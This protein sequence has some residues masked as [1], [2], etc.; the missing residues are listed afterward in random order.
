MPACFNSQPLPPLLVSLPAHPSPLSV[1]LVLLLPHLPSPVTLS[2]SRLSL[3]PQF[4]SLLL[5]FLSLQLLTLI[6]ISLRKRKLSENTYY[7]LLQPNL[8]NLL[9]WFPP[10]LLGNPQFLLTSK[11][12][13]R[14][15]V[16]SPAPLTFSCT[17]PIGL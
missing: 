12:L 15:E 14:L 6:L 13:T 9:Y 4:S 11:D 16:S 17:L 10:L 5:L 2:A 3:L 8:Q 7:W 1:Q